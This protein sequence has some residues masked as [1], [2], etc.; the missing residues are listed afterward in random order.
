M[1]HVNAVSFT[2]LIVLFLVVTLTGFAAGRWRRTGQLGAVRP[3]GLTVCCTP[4]RADHYSTS[5]LAT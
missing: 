2:I 3:G 5:M 4:L 1:S